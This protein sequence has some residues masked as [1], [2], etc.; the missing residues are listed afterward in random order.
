MRLENSLR[1]LRLIHKRDDY[2]YCLALEEVSKV[3][4]LMG[5]SQQ[6]ETLLNE[7]IMLFQD[8]YKNEYHSLM[9]VRYFRLAELK[10]NQGCYEHAKSL[11][12]K[13]IEINQ[14]LNRSQN[15]LSAVML[16]SKLCL[17]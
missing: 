14:R 5:N 4:E 7:S 17:Y 15:S 16:K 8:R 6:A 1:R 9:E 11:Y 13:I 2:Y 10:L 12:D 3:Y